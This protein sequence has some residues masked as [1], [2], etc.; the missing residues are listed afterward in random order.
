MVVGAVPFV[1]SIGGINFS[2][3]RKIGEYETLELAQRVKE[4]NLQSCEGLVGIFEIGE[5]DDSTF[6]LERE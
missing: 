1:S 3:L 6:R 2:G 5:K 4:L